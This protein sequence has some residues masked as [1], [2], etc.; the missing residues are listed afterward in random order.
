MDVL[1]VSESF[2]PYQSPAKRRRVAMTPAFLMG[3]L[4]A[5]I[6]WSSNARSCTGER[7]FVTLFAFMFGGVYLLYYVLVK[8]FLRFR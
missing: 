2:A 8:P 6:A 1:A 4:A 5:V 7:V 3:A